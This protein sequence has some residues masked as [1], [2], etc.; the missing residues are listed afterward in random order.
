MKRVI[1]LCILTII[2]CIVGEI[3]HA[4]HKDIPAESQVPQTE[5]KMTTPAV[6]RASQDVY[7]LQA[8][9]NLLEKKGVITKIELNEE[10]KRLKTGKK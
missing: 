9:I 7:T 8:L 3:T 4:I 10:I 5:G 1:T 6:T 2:F